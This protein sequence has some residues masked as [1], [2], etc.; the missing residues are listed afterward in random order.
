MFANFHDVLWAVLEM[1]C[2]NDFKN[3]ALTMKPYFIPSILRNCDDEF[4]EALV[5]YGFAEQQV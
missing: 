1:G 4:H 3:A 2:L 5:R